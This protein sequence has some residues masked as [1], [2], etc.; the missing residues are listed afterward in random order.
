MK[1][2]SRPSRL[3]AWALSLSFLCLGAAPLAKADGAVNTSTIVCDPSCSSSK[4]GY[5]PNIG[6]SS[7]VLADCTISGHVTSNGEAAGY[8]AIEDYELQ[9]QS[10]ADTTAVE[11][12]ADLYGINFDVMESA[13][14]A[15][16]CSG[17]DTRITQDI[18]DYHYGA[19]ETD[20][21]Y[22]S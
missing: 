11:S 9:S 2:L 19:T 12:Q 14:G 16:D 15:A 13:G 5:G 17:R 10:W 4:S 1:Q 3:G 20:S 7:G 6:V 18:D 21:T 22:F 8:W